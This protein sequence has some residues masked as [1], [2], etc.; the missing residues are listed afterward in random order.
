MKVTRGELKEL[1][2]EEIKEAE[3]DEGFFGDIAKSV[4]PTGTVDRMQGKKKLSPWD[5]PAADWSEGVGVYTL[6]YGDPKQHEYG[7]ERKYK[8]GKNVFNPI[9][10]ASNFHQTQQALK[11]IFRDLKSGQRP[12]KYGIEGLRI[13]GRIDLSNA[14]TKK[15]LDKK[16]Y[17]F[18][19]RPRDSWYPFE[20]AGFV[21]ETIKEQ[22][23][24]GGNFGLRTDPYYKALKK[25]Q[26]D[27]DTY[28]R[29]RKSANDASIEKSSRNWDGSK[30]S[31]ATGRKGP[32]A[33]NDRGQQAHGQYRQGVYR[34]FE[35]LTKK[36][37][38]KIIQE[39]IAKALQGK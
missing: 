31:Q 3:L 24:Q 6:Y 35:G 25:Q 38:E 2:A 39:E 36:E 13:Q 9:T 14:K 17:D 23:D 18:D 5:Y 16:Y 10:A 20:N 28:K 30:G 21:G 4:L 8:G 11:D 32:P 22:I 27:A 34:K 29:Q 15:E 26:D 37:I 12:Y 1:I 33:A 19:S 7:T